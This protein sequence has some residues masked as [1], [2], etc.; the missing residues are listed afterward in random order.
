MSRRAGDQVSTSA[1]DLIMQAIADCKDDD[2]R[3]ILLII[4]SGFSQLNA[5]VDSVLSNEEL[6]QRI[7]LNGHYEVHSEDHRWIAKERQFE[8]ENS[9]SKRKVGETLVSWVLVS[10]LSTLGAI[11]LVGLMKYTGI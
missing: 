5:K 9:G 4:H 3:A 8:Q 6:I 7:A 10:V 11:F 1:T 2:L